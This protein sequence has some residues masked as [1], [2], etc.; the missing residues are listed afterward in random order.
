MRTVGTPPTQ[1]Q[2]IRSPRSLIHANTIMHARIYTHARLQVALEGGGLVRVI[3]GSF[4]GTVGPARTFS[5][6]EVWDVSLP[7]AGRCLG[8][9]WQPCWGSN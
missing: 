5:P 2:A 4:R 9:R 3:A 7:E 8:G 1:H 6:V